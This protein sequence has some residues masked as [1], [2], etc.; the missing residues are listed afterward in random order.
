MYKDMQ[1]CVDVHPYML[2]KLGLKIPEANI[3]NSKFK[4]QN[5]DAA[6]KDTNVKKLVQGYVDKEK[7]LE[8]EDELLQKIKNRDATKAAK[9]LIKKN[10]EKKVLKHIKQY[11]NDKNKKRK[12]KDKSKQ[13]Q[14]SNEKEKSKQKEK[15]LK[16]DIQESTGKSDNDIDLEVALGEDLE[17]EIN[18]LACDSDVNDDHD[19]NINQ[20]QTASGTL[21]TDFDSWIDH[22][23]KQL[24]L[25]INQVKPKSKPLNPK[26]LGYR[27]GKKA[28]S[29]A[30][31]LQKVGDN[32]NSPIKPLVKTVESKFSCFVNV[33]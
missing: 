6:E 14:K 19:E 3:K 27:L 15:I 2:S 12:R 18:K 21:S 20:S 4:Y 9:K 32:D 33:V 26:K 24:N 13:K 29:L 5:L 1:I 10:Q 31:S 28:M 17:R 30:V 11:N 22:H 7:E 8:S 25:E 16:E 23:N